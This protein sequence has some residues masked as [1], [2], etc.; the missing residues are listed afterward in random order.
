[1]LIPNYIKNSNDE[2]F[3]EDNLSFLEKVFQELLSIV[4]FPEY[5]KNDEIK[6]NIW[7]EDGITLALAPVEREL[8]R[9]SFTHEVRVY[10]KHPEKI[11][12]LHPLTNRLYLI[13]LTKK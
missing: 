11:K 9:L 8:P 2:I 6:V 7:N 13:Y 1:M 4:Y 3:G 5:S 12:I 10:E